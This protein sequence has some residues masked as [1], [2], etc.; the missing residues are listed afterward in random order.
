MEKIQ[1]DSGM[2]AYRI[3]GGGVL[4]FNPAD[5]NV[6]VRFLEAVEQVKTLEAGLQG[7]DPLSACKQADRQLKQ[8]LGQVFGEHN[9]FD[10]LLGGVSLL[11][12]AGNGQTV[13]SNLLSAL[14]P[15]LEE[16]AQSY[17]GELT[18]RAVEKA[19]R[20]RANGQ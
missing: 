15:I 8:L 20:R 17:A 11:A 7:E 18:A 10:Q 2:K 4:R 3:N 14:L 1:I 12:V 6:Y 13:M 16:G 19:Q 9:D 5:P